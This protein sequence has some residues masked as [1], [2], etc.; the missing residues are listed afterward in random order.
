MKYSVRIDV[1]P[2]FVFLIYFAIMIFTPS[3][4]GDLDQFK[5]H[6]AIGIIA[7]LLLFVGCLLA[8]ISLVRGIGSKAI[9][10]VGLVACASPLVMMAAVA[11]S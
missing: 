8:V 1:I 2:I 11:L 3:D 4:I 9:A 10:L 6:A 5:Y 7:T